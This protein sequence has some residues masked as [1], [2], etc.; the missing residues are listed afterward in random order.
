LAEDFS[1]PVMKVEN[2]IGLEDESDIVERHVTLL[3]QRKHILVWP[4]GL[5][6]VS[7]L[8]GL[9]QAYDIITRIM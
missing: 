7:T 1:R 2:N 6:S 4:A 3:Q 9:L 5:Y 8:G